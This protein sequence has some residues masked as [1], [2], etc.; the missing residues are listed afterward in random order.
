MADFSEIDK[1]RKVLGLGK[2][3]TLKEIKKVYR[4]LSLKYHPDRCKDKKE[5]EDMFKKINHANEVLMAYCAGYCYS[6]GKEDV[7]RT[8]M[9]EEF[10]EH[11][12]RFYDDWWGDLKI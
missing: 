1:S 6:F 12:R 3:A 4:K 10:R 2:T 9:D 5:C 8:S 11:L 7:K